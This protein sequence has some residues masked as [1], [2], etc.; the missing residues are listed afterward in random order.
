MSGDEALIRAF[1][2]E[3]D[4]HRATAAKIF[5]VSPDLVSHEMRFAAKRI[6]FALLYGMAAFTLGKELGVSTSEAKSYVDSY[7][8]QFPSVR[9]TLDG[10]PRAGAAHAGGHDA[11]R[12]GAAD[13]RHRR[14]QPERCAATP[15][16]WR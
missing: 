12:P 13:P 4:I 5:G 14:V 16:A 9:A 3:Q 7:F 11:L 10:D 2:E 1:E 6:N 8:A 15:S